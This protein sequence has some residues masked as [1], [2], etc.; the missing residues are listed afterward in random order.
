[1]APNL[2]RI[3]PA[4]LGIAVLAALILY[5]GGVFHG[6]QIG[7]EDARL[8]AREAPSAAQRVAARLEPRPLFH[9]AVGTVQAVSALRIEAQVAAR[10]SRIAVRPGDLVQKGQLLVELDDREPRAR[11]GQAREALNAALQRQVQAERAIDAA[12]ALQARA[13]AQHGRIRSFLA[14]EAATAQEMEQVEAELRQ[15]EAGRAQARAALAQTRAGIE[16]ARRALD[17][18]AVQL[19]HARIHSPLAGQVVERL[20]EPGDLA[21]PGRPLLSLQSESAL[22][23]E[24]LVPEALIERLT[25]GEKMVVEIGGR[26]F[27]GVVDEQVPA[28]DSR[29]RSFVVKVGLPPADGLYPGMFGR[30]RVPLDARPAVLVPLAA[31][32]R[33]GQLEMVRRVEDDQVKTLL[34]TTGSRVGGDIEVLSGLKG[35]EIL[36]VDGEQP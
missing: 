10:V 25:L 35:G 29:A 5:M 27:G 4:L 12:D 9:E 15:A 22:R 7:P 34:V 26:E 16:Q 28:A 20:A 14:A 6:D 30:L 3:A 19:G 36:L 23:L 21:V 24:A 13:Q 11:H 33:V 18:A 32:R 17:E 8:P 31:V 1:M 2:K